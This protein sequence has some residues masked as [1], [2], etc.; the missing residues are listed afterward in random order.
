MDLMLDSW[1]MQHS[2]SIL[3]TL[4][5]VTHISHE[6]REG[7]VLGFKDRR[8]ARKEQ[9]S[10]NF[11]FGTQTVTCT[12]GFGCR[13]LVVGFAFRF[14]ARLGPKKSTQAKIRTGISHIYTPL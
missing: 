12:P 11:Q 13:I 9:R 1:K 6:P 8:M 4:P 10:G 7:V 3:S 14:E 5:P 2:T